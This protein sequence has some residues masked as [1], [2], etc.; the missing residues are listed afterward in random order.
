MLSEKHVNVCYFFM[1]VPQLVLALSVT[2]E[3]RM[4]KKKILK[5]LILIIVWDMCGGV[6]LVWGFWTGRVGG[7]QPTKLLSQN[8]FLLVVL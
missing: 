2:F 4:S 3:E 8:L 1:I 7:F 6:F 5:A